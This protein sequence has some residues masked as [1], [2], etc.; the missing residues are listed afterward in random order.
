MK[1]NIIKWDNNMA[2]RCLAKYQ[3]K[4]AKKYLLHGAG[5]KKPAQEKA[6]PEKECTVDIVKGEWDDFQYA[7]NTALKKK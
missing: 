3:D 6:S 2:L 4:L 1:T 7:V 5:S